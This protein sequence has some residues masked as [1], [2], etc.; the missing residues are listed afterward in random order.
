MA[1]AIVANSLVPDVNSTDGL[2]PSSLKS[3][4]KPSDTPASSGDSDHSVKIICLGDSAVG[5][6]KLVERFLLDDYIPQQSSTYAVN[7]FKYSTKVR[8]KRVAVEI[9]DTG[10]QERFNTMHPSYYHGSQACI[11]VFDV[12]RKITYK[13][14]ANW[15]KEMR[16]FR[17]DIPCLV[18]ANK[19]DIDL[20]VTQKA[21]NFAAKH[22]LPMYFVSASSGVNVVKVFR[23]AIKLSVAYK[24]NSTDF[25]DEIMKELELMGNIDTETANDTCPCDIK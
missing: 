11:L 7:L 2:P 23:D 1:E 15:Y 9:W 8:G 20:R 18:V 6:S 16:H 25:M 12:E 17:P 21:F 10:G 22:Q 5:K 14:L 19:I 3:E 13:N 24:E 4:D